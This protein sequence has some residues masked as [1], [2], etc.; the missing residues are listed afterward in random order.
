MANGTAPAGILGSSANKS[1]N[2][3]NNLFQLRPVRV[4][5]IITSL[6]YQT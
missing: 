2:R 4:V 6:K 5:D 1:I 3:R